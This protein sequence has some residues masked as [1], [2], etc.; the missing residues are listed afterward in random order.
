MQE[1]FSSVDRTPPHDVTS[2]SF[3][4]PVERAV[5]IQRGVGVHQKQ[6]LRFLERFELGDQLP[7]FFRSTDQRKRHYGLYVSALIGTLAQAAFV[8]LR[9]AESTF[10]SIVMRPD[11]GRE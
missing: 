8:F 6:Q 10:G 9:L 4:D 7:R 5:V 3:V 2:D 1:L 11:D